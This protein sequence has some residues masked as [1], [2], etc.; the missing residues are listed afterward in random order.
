[1]NRQAI[2]DSELSN[3]T[4]PQ[5]FFEYAVAYRNA[6]LAMCN[7][8]VNDP[9]LRTWPNANV[10]LLLAAHSTELF[11]KGAILSR[12]PTA[13]IEHHRLDKLA[14]E[15]K[16]LFPESL[17][18]WKIPFRAESDHLSDT[19]IQTVLETLPIPSMLYRYPVSKGGKEWNGVFAFEASSFVAV[20]EQVDQDFQRIMANIDQSTFPTDT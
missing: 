1:M 15:Y 19:E 18:E 20:L 10:V 2:T 11:L 7:L 13:K 9:A 3:L 17:F 6:A 8:M 14:T 5:R 16:Y 12:N 4:V